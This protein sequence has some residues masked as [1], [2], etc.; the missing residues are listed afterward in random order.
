L[1]HY[2]K[3]ISELRKEFEYVS[4]KH[5]PREENQMVDVLAT[6]SS[7]FKVTQESDVAPIQISIYTTLIYCQ[8][9]E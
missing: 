5:L 8:N 7:M 2:G 6:L 3:L 9:I 4:F 1:A